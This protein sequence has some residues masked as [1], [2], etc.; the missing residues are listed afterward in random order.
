MLRI[1]IATIGLL[2]LGVVLHVQQ[3]DAQSERAAERMSPAASAQA[4][5]PDLEKLLSGR[6]K[7]VL[8]VAF[9]ENGGFTPFRAG[10]VVERD[11]DEPV[12]PEARD[13]KSFTVY[14]YRKNPHCYSYWSGSQWKEVCPQ[15]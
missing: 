9:D 1:G 5:G 11:M 3:T 14:F 13:V 4:M 15:H 2:I 6:G 8:S 12:P 7:P 10:D